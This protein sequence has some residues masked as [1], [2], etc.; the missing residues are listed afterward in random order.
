[1]HGCVGKQL[2]LTEMKTLL[3]TL[4]S[5][6]DFRCDDS[7]KL[8]EYREFSYSLCNVSFEMRPRARIQL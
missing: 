5:L 4:I 8:L 6:Y 7:Q 1:M 2:A 3:A